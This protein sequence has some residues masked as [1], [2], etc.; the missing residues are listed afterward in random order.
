VTIVETRDL[1]DTTLIAIATPDSGLIYQWGYNSAGLTPN[2]ISG[3]TTQD[4]LLDTGQNSADYWVIV[5]DTNTHCSAK[6]FV[7]A[8]TTTTGIK[9]INGADARVTVYPNPSSDKFTLTI[10]ST[11]EQS[12]SIEITDI[13]GKQILET[14]TNKEQNVEWQVNASKWS[15]GTYLL[16]VRSA[17]GDT[18]VLKL[19]RE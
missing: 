6:V 11:T 13:N 18:K 12:W 8:P 15:E 3:A 7:N 2:T 14:Q 5:T 9:D 10:R 19:I 1:I 17:S 4:L 16:R